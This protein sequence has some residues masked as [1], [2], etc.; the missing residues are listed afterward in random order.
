ML[1]R[2]ALTDIRRDTP[3][4]LLSSSVGDLSQLSISKSPRGQQ[5][6]RRVEVQVRPQ[7]PQS[8]TRTVPRVVSPRGEAGY[9]G[10]RPSQPQ[11]RES[12]ANKMVYGVDPDKTGGEY[13]WSL[14]PKLVQ[15]YSGLL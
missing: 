14:N 1:K 12:M 8:Q 10:A 9:P 5:E 7:Q 11:P 2:F 15:V 3:D 6:P 13:K 4:L